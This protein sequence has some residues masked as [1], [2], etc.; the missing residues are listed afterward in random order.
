MADYRKAVVD[1]YVISKDVARI[2]ELL[3]CIRPLGAARVVDTG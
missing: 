1:L 3:F 2:A